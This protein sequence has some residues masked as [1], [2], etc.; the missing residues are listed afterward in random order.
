VPPCLLAPHLPLPSS[1]LRG[2][3]PSGRPH[4]QAGRPVGVSTLL[5]GPMAAGPQ[6]C[7]TAGSPS[8]AAHGRTRRAPPPPPGPLGSAGYALQAAPVP[9]FCRRQTASNAAAGP[10]TCRAPQPGCSALPPSRPHPMAPTLR[11]C[12]TAC[13]PAGGTC[14]SASSM[15]VRASGA[16]REREPGVGQPCSPAVGGTAGKHGWRLVLLLPPAALRPASRGSMGS[17][18]VPFRAA[19]RPVS[20]GSMGSASVPFR[21]ALFPRSL[22]H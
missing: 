6:G 4:L 8:A 14:T 13:L 3:L 11:P 15:Q 7:C 1:G 12:G 18:S 9:C 5:C 10:C 2:Q 22:L 21:A 20:R 16:G 19:L 17:A